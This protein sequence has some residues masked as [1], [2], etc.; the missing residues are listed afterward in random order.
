MIILSLLH[1][2]K[3]SNS[4]FNEENG[5]FY[6]PLTYTQKHKYNEDGLLIM[7]IAGNPKHN[8]QAE[9]LYE[10][11]VATLGQWRNPLH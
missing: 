8:I 5:Y 6:I 2:W 4:S 11:L 3:D 1:E 7:M 10:P 9:V